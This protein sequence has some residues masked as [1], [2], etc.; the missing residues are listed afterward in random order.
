MCLAHSIFDKNKHNHLLLLLVF[1]TT[2][3]TRS[4]QRTRR[5]HH[6]RR[7][8]QSCCTMS[9]LLV[10]NKTKKYIQDNRHVQTH[11]H[12]LFQFIH[13]RENNVKILCSRH[14]PGSV[15]AINP[16]DISEAFVK[17][18][19]Q[20][21]THEINGNTRYVV[22]VWVCCS[23]YVYMREWWWMFESLRQLP[24][25]NAYRYILYFYSTRM[26]HHASGREYGVNYTIKFV[27]VYLWLIYQTSRGAYT[28]HIIKLNVSTRP[29]AFL[30]YVMR[31]PNTEIYA[32]CVCSTYAFQSNIA[33]V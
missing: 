12:T 19:L 22:I 3:E 10:E 4:I 23:L 11:T 32:H 30:W 6:R 24:W 29:L 26:G 28:T 14:A 27:R 21:D 2:I 13:S 18:H 7:H 1:D 15:H 17:K 16:F 31:T 5:F 25:S 9:T 33:R 20:I 8:Q